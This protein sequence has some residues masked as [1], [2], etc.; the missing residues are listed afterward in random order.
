VQVDKVMIEQTL[1]NLMRNGMD[2]MAD[3]L[4]DQRVLTISTAP[5]DNGVRVTVADHGSGIPGEVAQHLYEPFFS[6]KQ[7]GMGMGLSICRSIAEL[8]RGRLWFEARPDGGTLFHL[9]LPRSV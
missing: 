6:T 3:T 2:A 8:H 7:E 9:W 4:P 1:L 5:H